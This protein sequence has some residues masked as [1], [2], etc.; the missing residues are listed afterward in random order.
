MPVPPM[1]STA[2]EWIWSTSALTP[3]LLAHRQPQNDDRGYRGEGGPL[4]AEDEDGQKPGEAGG[5]SR[6]E[7]RQPSAPEAEGAR[8]QTLED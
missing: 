5:N 3:R 2:E 4:Q 6:L 1:R 7:D 8:E